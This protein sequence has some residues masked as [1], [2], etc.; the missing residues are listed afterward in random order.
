[1]A[2]RFSIDQ[3]LVVVDG[4]ETGVRA[5]RFA[6]QM[7]AAQ[8]AKL[9]GLAVVDTATLSSLLKKSVLVEA[10]MEEFGDELE[11]S[12]RSNLKYLARLAEEAGVQSQTLLRKGSA[13]WT[14]IDEVKRIEPDLLVMGSFTTS[15]IK[16]DLNARERRLIVDEVQCPIILVP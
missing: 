12:A 16:R 4:T 3:I 5:A 8:G 15:T 13:H 14:V 2:E 7:A 6:A 11:S 1:M 10:E 9:T